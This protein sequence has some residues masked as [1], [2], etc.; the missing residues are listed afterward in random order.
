MEEILEAVKI[1]VIGFSTV[2]ATL[3][4]LYLFMVLLG[5]LLGPKVEVGREE[6][7]VTSSVYPLGDA[8]AAEK[9]AAIAA[10][11]YE[12][13]YHKYGE[14]RKFVITGIRKS[15]GTSSKN[16]WLME[17]RKELLNAGEELER[18]RRERY[19]KKVF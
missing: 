18:T 2:I 1:M 14:N 15:T 16:T 5:K 7:P 4:I 11:V 6:T 19:G 3:F 9:I 8:I 13:I 10:A 17:G 12:C